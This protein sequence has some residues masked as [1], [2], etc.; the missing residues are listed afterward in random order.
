QRI[1]RI[2]GPVGTQHAV[3]ELDGSLCEAKLDAERFQVGPQPGV[4]D[5]AGQHLL[6]QRRPVVRRARLGARE[7]PPPPGAAGAPLPPAAR[8][9]PGV[10]QPA[11]A[12]PDDDNSRRGHRLSSSMRQSFLPAVVTVAASAHGPAEGPGRTGSRILSSSK[13]LAAMISP[14]SR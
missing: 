4:V 7:R 3:A 2:F 14:P 8:R 5:L 13:A 9:S 12:G 11:E 10:A 6:R 1:P